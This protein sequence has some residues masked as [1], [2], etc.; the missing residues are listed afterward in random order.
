MAG[1]FAPKCT[2]LICCTSKLPQKSEKIIKDQ[3]PVSEGDGLRP[4]KKRKLCPPPRVGKRSI[5]LFNLRLE[6]GSLISV[7]VLLDC[8]SVAPMLSQSLALRYN[9]P[10]IRR[11]KP[12]PY[13]DFANIVVPGSAE[14]YSYEMELSYKGHYSMETFEIG[15]CD[16]EVDIILPAWWMAKHPPIGYLWGKLSFSNKKCQNCTQEKVHKVEVTYD[17]SILDEGYWDEVKEVARVSSTITVKDDLGERPITVDDILP[18][19]YKWYMRV[20]NEELASQLP[21]HRQWDHAI[22]LK[23]GETAPWDP[24][25]PLSQDQLKALWEYLK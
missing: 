15:P 8:G 11:N 2:P 22:D 24:I 23:P 19:C 25:Y 12:E 14:A 21:P 20:F 1:V 9:I 4:T 16:D 7:R 18:S 3:R 6:D 13:T 5:F 10:R 17:E